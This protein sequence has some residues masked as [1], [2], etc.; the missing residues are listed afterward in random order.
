MR[1]FDVVKNEE[2]SEEQL[3][4]KL[5]TMYY[6]YVS[7]NNIEPFTIKYGRGDGFCIEANSHVG[8][9]THDD[10][11][12]YIESMIPDLSLGKILYLQSQAE[13]VADSSSTKNVISEQLNEEEN[14]AAVDYFII[15]LV[16][17][18]EDI[19]QNG[20]ISELKSTE[21]ISP[22]VIGKINRGIT[23]SYA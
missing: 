21:E 5:A 4:Q 20:L 3:Y 10:M 22:Q 12:L 11:V 9:I 7:S 17:S 6:D 2:I 18:V 14:I 19:K 16:N 1:D 13:E 8:V 23:R 15:S